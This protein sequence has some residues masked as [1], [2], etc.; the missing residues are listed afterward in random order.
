MDDQSGF[1]ANTRAA[2]CA[3][4]VTVLV[5]VAPGVALGAGVVPGV[6]DV[7]GFGEAPVQAIAKMAAAEMSTRGL[8]VVFVMAQRRTGAMQGSPRPHAA[9]HERPVSGSTSWC[10]MLRVWL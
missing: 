2:A 10:G 4:V 1:E 7:D 5:G 9:V 3:A 6:G 8:E